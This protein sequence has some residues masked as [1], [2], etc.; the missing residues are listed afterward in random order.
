[1]RIR[2]PNPNPNCKAMEEEAEPARRLSGHC[3]G[4][5]DQKNVS[6]IAYREDGGL[7]SGG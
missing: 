6:V 3:D 4:P 2:V 5:K 7:L 1:M